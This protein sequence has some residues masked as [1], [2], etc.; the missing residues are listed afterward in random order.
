MRS[1]LTCAVI[2]SLLLISCSRTT[3]PRT[4]R[5]ATL[6]TVP[7][8]ATTTD[9]DLQQYGGTVQLRTATFAVIGNPS[10][11]GLGAQ[12]STLESNQDA[13]S[14]P[15]G[16]TWG[17]AKGLWV[18]GVSTW[19][20]A[21][22]L[23][24][25]SDDA[26]LPGAGNLFR[27]E[28]AG[29]FSA[30][31]LDDLL[32]TGRLGA[33]QVVA[34]I[35]TGFDTQHPLLSGNLTDAGTWYDFVND[36]R[37]P[38]FNVV[39][40]SPSYGHGTFVAG[41]VRQTAPRARIMPLQVLNDAGEG[42]IVNA[43]RAIV[44]AADH[45]ANVINLSFGTAQSSPAL[46]EAIR[47]AQSRQSLVVAA[48]GN[49]AQAVM[50]HP[51]EGLD[52]A[53]GGISVGSHGPDHVI[54]AF[55]SYSP[56]TYAFLPGEALFSAFPNNQAGYWSGTSMSAPIMAGILADLN[57]NALTVQSTLNALS[58]TRYSIS[59]LQGAAYAAI[60]AQ[61]VRLDVIDRAR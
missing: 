19:S 30:I 58:S 42:D 3:L 23:W 12:A 61:S 56:Q 39:S 54:S 46:R 51:A 13:I 26:L 6:L 43:A 44:W 14:V 8:T 28:N 33:G 35:D 52:S 59:A 49:S 29:N 15:E 40:G 32:K 17:N 9:Q 47:Y 48:A 18:N 22:G 57:Q 16:S 50:D 31:H 27:V 25:N 21:K 10:R 38:A 1:I 2:S 34:V 45:G 53:A 37:A 5:P 24:V 41:L 36:D 4:D 11:A 60:S 7:V 55:S 20:S